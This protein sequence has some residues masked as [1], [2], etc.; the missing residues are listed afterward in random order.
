MLLKQGYSEF[1]FHIFPTCQNSRIFSVEQ[2]PLSCCSLYVPKET[3][4]SL[5][6]SLCP[7]SVGVSIAN[8]PGARG[9][10]YCDTQSHTHRLLLCILY[11]PT[12]K[13]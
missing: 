1:L 9:P 7:T 3:A 6:R 11:G 5:S 13:V 10:T 4:E 2:L 12:L 8:L